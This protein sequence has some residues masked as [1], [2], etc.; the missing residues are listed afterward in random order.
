MKYEAIVQKK[1]K[2]NKNS[3][4]SKRISPNTEKYASGCRLKIKASSKRGGNRFW[5]KTGT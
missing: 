4:E 1:E 3:P 2:Q 5:L